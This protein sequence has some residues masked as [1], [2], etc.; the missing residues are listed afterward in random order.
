MYVTIFVG[1]VH[2]AVFFFFGHLLYLNTEGWGTKYN[3]TYSREGESMQAFF[4]GEE[5]INAPSLGKVRYRRR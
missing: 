2:G 1:Q 4:C 3:N 5:Q